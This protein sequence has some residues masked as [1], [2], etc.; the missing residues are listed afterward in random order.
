MAITLKLKARFLMSN[1]YLHLLCNQ[2]SKICINLNFF[3]KYLKF[4]FRQN[5]MFKRSVSILI[6]FYRD[7]KLQYNTYYVLYTQNEIFKTFN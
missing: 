2:I 3:Y 6:I 1:V 7:L 5:S 4:K